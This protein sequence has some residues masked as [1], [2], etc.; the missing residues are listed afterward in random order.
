MNREIERFNSLVNETKALSG[1][2]DEDWLTMV[3]IV[4]KTVAEGDIVR[5]RGYSEAVRW[6]MGGNGE[7]S[8]VFRL[9]S[10]G[11]DSQAVVR[12]LFRL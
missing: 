10:D 9:S 8:E 2:N 12:S 3:E 11:E 4:Y 5:W 7:F 1:E 6:I